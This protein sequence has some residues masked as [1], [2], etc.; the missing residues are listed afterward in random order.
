MRQAPATSAPPS[1]PSASA[2]WGLQH[3]ATLIFLHKLAYWT[4]Q[5]EMPSLTRAEIALGGS[6]W[7]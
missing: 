1:S 4:G 6:T 5:T 7:S 3:P 2:S